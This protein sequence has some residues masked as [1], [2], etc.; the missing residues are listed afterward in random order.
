MWID[1]FGYTHNRIEIKSDNEVPIVALND[2]MSET[3]SGPTVPSAG[4]ARESKSNGAME[5]RV[6]AW[7]RNVRTPLVDLEENI[8]GELYLG[9]NVSSWLVMWAATSLNKFRL[10]SAGRT[11][12]YRVTGG[13]HRRPIAKFGE[14]IWW[15]PNGPRDSGLKAETRTCEGIYLGIRNQTSESLIATE[16]GITSARTVRR[17]P[18]DQKG[19]RDKVLNIKLSVA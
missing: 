11:A 8:G 12:F 18:A 13:S 16:H 9:N 1:A 5:T 14:C 6:K 10:D 15:L 4:P 2:L 7:Q 19:D 17:V 3:R